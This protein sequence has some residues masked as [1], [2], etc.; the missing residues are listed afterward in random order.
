[1]YRMKIEGNPTHNKKEI[2]ENRARRKRE[3]KTTTNIN[4]Y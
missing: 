3:F 1:M 4:E 2:V